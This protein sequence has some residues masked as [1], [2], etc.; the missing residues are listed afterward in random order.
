MFFI[1]F[2]INVIFWLIV[3]YIFSYFVIC[4]KEYVM[5]IYHTG[6]KGKKIFAIIG[7]LIFTGVAIYEQYIK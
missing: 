2:L 6:K 1:K 7:S 4:I 5:D 3:G